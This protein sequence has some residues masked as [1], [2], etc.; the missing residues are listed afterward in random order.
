MLREY[1][2]VNCRRVT[3]NFHTIHQNQKKTLKAVLLCVEIIQAVNK[4]KILKSGM[5]MC[6]TLY[7]GETIG[8]R[9]AELCRIVLVSIYYIEKEV[10][11]C[12]KNEEAGNK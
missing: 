2:H 3:G 7:Q 9:Y 5:F 4:C 10:V 8:R 6:E 11:F 12:G 1:P